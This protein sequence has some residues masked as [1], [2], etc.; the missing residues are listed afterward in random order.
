MTHGL[1]NMGKS[2]ATLKDLKNWKV[3]GILRCLHIQIHIHLVLR[4]STI[5]VNPKVVLV[6]GVPFE[7]RINCYTQFCIIWRQVISAQRSLLQVLSL[8]VC[9]YQLIDIW[10]VDSDSPLPG[11]W[12]SPWNRWVH[13]IHISHHFKWFYI[14]DLHWNL[15]MLSWSKSLP[16]VGLGRWASTLDVQGPTLNCP[17]GKTM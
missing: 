16:V 1:E 6:P 10:L 9:V 15:P 8:C 5:G 14:T 3:K 13:I 4:C 7:E 11:L 12:Y 17:A 2:S